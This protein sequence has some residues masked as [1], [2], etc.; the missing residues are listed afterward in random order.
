MA[1]DRMLARLV[2]HIRTHGLPADASLRRLAEELGTSHRMLAYYFGSRDGLLAAVLTAM[3]AEERQTLTSTAENW[4]PRDAALAMWSFYT[5]PAQVSEHKAFF[6]VFSLALQ[7]PK[8][9]AEFLASLDTW[10]TLTAE[11][12]A[13]QGLGR[14]Q[15]A[16]RAQLMVSAIRGL[17]MDRLTTSNR[18]R[19]DAAFT[20]LLNTLLPA[21]DHVTAP[22]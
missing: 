6:Y 18:D 22:A 15:A 14:D 2:T 8:T 3:R 20:L 10:V 21:S 1:R 5:D 4:S 19:V 17:L 12:T 7:Q 16:A 11:L 13:A 9:Y